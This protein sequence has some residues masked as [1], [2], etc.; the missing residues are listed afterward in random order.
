MTD[1]AMYSV[2]LKELMAQASP[3]QAPRQAPKFPSILLAAME[4]M[5]LSVDTPLLLKVLS[6][7]LF[8]QSWGTLRFDDHRGLLPRDFKSLGNGSPG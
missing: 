8:V 6:W 2:S 4:D 5:V 3:G 7:W 1:T